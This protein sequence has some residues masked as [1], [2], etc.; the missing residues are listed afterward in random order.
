MAV[1]GSSFPGAYLTTRA[2][3]IKELC[4]RRRLRGVSVPYSTAF[5]NV[6]EIDEMY[7]DG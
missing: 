4:H 7:A 6:R 1:L 3:S 2:E 5:R